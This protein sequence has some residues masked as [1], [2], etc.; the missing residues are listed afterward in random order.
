MGTEAPTPRG[1]GWLAALL[2]LLFPPAGMRGSW[3][4][5]SGALAPAPEEDGSEEPG[6]PEGGAQRLAPEAVCGRPK[7]TGRIYGGRDVAAGRWPWQAS[8]LHKRMHVCGAV[9]IDPLWL[10]SAAHCFLNKSHAPT[11][12]QV[13]LGSTQLYQHTQHTREMPLSRIIVHPDFEKRHPF[14][15]D[16]AMLQL[17]LPVNLTSSIAP[18]CLPSPGMQLSGNLSCW[19]T[20]WGMLSE[21]KHLHSPFHL[22]EGKVNLVENEF[23]NVLY[24]QRLSNS[25]SHSVR[26]EMLCAGDFSTGRAICQGDSGGPLVCDLPMAWVLVGLASWGLDCWHPV[27]PSV[28]TRVN[29]FTDWINKIRR[30]TPPLDPTSAPQIRVPDQ[31]LQATGS[32]S[33]GTALVPP[34]TWLLLLFALRDS[35]QALR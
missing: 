12:Y 32:S 4:V 13:L 24:R 23:C 26:E 22:Q 7:V 31:P 33:S 28:F 35:R 27:Y 16:I 18:A 3:S 34:Q 6:R 17:H 8:L 1:R 25:K 29:Y 15:S 10:L 11:D 30:L 21:D 2:W 19:I 9:L 20:G 5:A 14:G